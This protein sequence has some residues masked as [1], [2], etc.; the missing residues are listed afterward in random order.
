M[1]TVLAWIFYWVGD[2]A[3]K[4]LE[5]KDSERWINFW[6]PVYNNLM[7]FSVKAQGESDKGPWEKV[8]D[9]E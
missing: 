8:Q 6:Y 5:L 1:K 7:L 2:G 9:K 3:S 4:I